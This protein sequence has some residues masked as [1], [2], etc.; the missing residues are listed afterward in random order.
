MTKGGAGSTPQVRCFNPRATSEWRWR[1]GLYSMVSVTVHHERRILNLEPPAH[2]DDKSKPSFCCLI[3]FKFSGDIDPAPMPRP[4]SF[5]HKTDSPGWSHR[6]QHHFSRTNISHKTQ[7][8]G[9][10]TNL[11][12]KAHC[13]EHLC[14]REPPGPVGT[15]ALSS[16]Q[17]MWPLACHRPVGPGLPDWSVP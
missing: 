13:S 14:S 15:E 4:Q 6:C 16:A 10:A 12:A 1:D 7:G 3:V 8:F 17:L 11:N 2:G 9:W 5:I